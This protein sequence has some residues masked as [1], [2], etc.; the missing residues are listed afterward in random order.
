MEFKEDKS[1]G[2]ICMAQDTDHLQVLVNMVMNLC[3]LKRWGIS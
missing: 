2:W 1:L 3:I